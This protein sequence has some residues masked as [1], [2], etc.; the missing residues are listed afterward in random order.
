MHEWFV[1]EVLNLHPHPVNVCV[2][3]GNRAHPCTDWCYSGS[4][5]RSSC[6]SLRCGF[7]FLLS[8]PP[9]PLVSSPSFSI[10]CLYSLT[11]ACVSCSRLLLLL[12]LPVPLLHLFPWSCCLFHLVPTFMCLSRRA[13]R[14]AHKPCSRGGILCF[15]CSGGLMPSSPGI[16]SMA[17]G[18]RDWRRG[19]RC[20][21]IAPAWLPLCAHW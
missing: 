8:S 7:C 14:S 5:S 19:Q 20:L 4:L 17:R 21:S 9:P 11:S 3:N 16:R 10:C 13:I 1:P 2:E 12:F 18:K 15:T 6:S